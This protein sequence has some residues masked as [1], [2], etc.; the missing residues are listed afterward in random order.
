MKIKL[1]SVKC[2]GYYPDLGVIRWSFELTDGETEQVI[3]LAE[4]HRWPILDTMT[5]EQKTKWLFS[6]YGHL[7]KLVFGLD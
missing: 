6:K 5:M 2:L 7:V 1:I 4:N 3:I